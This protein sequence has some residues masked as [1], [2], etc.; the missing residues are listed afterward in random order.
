MTARG[1]RQ[2][3]AAVT[4]SGQAHAATGG[5]AVSGVV[6]GD[7]AVHAAPAA[8]S[9]YRQQVLRIAPPELVGR[10][11]ELDELAAFCT[12]PDRGPYVWWQAPAWAGKTALMSWFALNPPQSAKILPFFITARFAGQSDRAAFTEVVA[13]Q[14]A[15][16]LGQPAPAHLTE[17]TR[18]GHLLSMLEDAAHRCQRRGER[19]VLLVDGLDED[20]GVT[21]GPDAYSIAALLPARPPAGLRV[22]VAGRPHPP[23]PADVP[24]HHPLRDPDIVRPL[25]GSPHAA[26]VR[27]DM[28]RELVR[29]LRGTSEERDLLGLVAAAGGGL[30]RSD[31]AELTSINTW[32]VAQHLRAVTGRTFA[33]RTARRQRTAGP[34]EDAREV[35]VLAHEELQK[36]ALTMLGLDRL[37]RYRERLHTWAEIYRDQGWPLATPEYLLRGY[38]RMLRATADLPRAVACATDSARHD[39]MRESTGGDAAALNEIDAAEALVLACEEPDLVSTALIAVHRR[40]LLER[41][42]YPLSLPVVWAAAGQPDRAEALARAMDDPDHVG[43]ALGKIAKVAGL[44]G[45]RARAAQLADTI[46][47]LDGFD[48]ACWRARRMAAVA[49]AAGAA[50]DHDRAAALERAMDVV[51]ADATDGEKADVLA[52]GARAAAASGNRRRAGELADAIEELARRNAHSWW[53]SDVE[54]AAD[55]KEPERVTIALRHLGVLAGTVR[56]AQRRAEIEAS[57]AVAAAAGIGQHG[58]AL[59]EAAA[60]LSRWAEPPLW[61]LE[62]IEPLTQAVAASGDAPRAARLVDLLAAAAAVPAHPCWQDSASSRSLARAAVEALTT[63]A[64]RERAAVLSQS[65]ETVARAPVVEDKGMLLVAAAG[66]AALAGQDARAG[67][68]AAAIT[69]PEGQSEALALLATVSLGRGDHRRATALVTEAERVCRDNV[70]PVPRARALAALARA[71]D[72][73][74]NGERTG[75]LADALAA[76]ADA[77]AAPY[78]RAEVQVEQVGVLALVGQTDRAEALARTVT[79]LWMRKYVSARLVQTLSVRREFDR[80]EAFILG[81]VDHEELSEASAALTQAAIRHGALDR[82][83]RLLDVFPGSPRDQAQLLASFAR[84]AAVGGAR[85]RACVLAASLQD[86]ARLCAGTEYR[87]SVACYAVEALAWSRCFDAAEELARGITAPYWRAAA[88]GARVKAATRSGEPGLAA[89]L[90]NRAEMSMPTDRWGRSMWLQHLAE[91]ATMTG[92]MGAA[93]DLAERIPLPAWRADTLAKLAQF[94]EPAQGRRLMARALALGDWRDLL[95]SLLQ[96]APAALPAL[97]DTLLGWE[98]TSDGYAAG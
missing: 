59:R 91:A 76:L 14:L 37:S 4:S 35:Y 86:L 53:R 45:D 27:A 34:G 96:F 90:A 5:V 39:R 52:A 7:V 26:A 88:M 54:W 23:I 20:R 83:A 33:T 62:V 30:S 77:T 17:A 2:P 51:L 95:E 11:A 71:T 98:E 3:L 40:R 81:L 6:H 74:G 29:L 25:D 41:N 82:A 28:E 65:M 97:T 24:A 44:G 10:Q 32:E 87:E 75:R 72:A 70:R 43:V 22:I 61:L 94:V 92:R 69:D 93:L 85:L 8:R 64:D 21:T 18:E 47:G 46:E 1:W 9:G 31:L 38:A 57:L 73:A 50:G 13:E 48:S 16:S 66:A 15:A 80:A 84:S 60:E 56:S 79:P 12:A 19:L 67:A 89:V 63:C 36:T 58:V 55:A 78:W 42:T 49:E 68:L